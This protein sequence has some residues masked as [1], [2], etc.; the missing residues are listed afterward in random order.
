MDGRY[1]VEVAVRCIFSNV[2][3]GDVMR[4]LPPRALRLV[5][6]LS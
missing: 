6:S 2:R 1:A 5:L 4:Q 3:I